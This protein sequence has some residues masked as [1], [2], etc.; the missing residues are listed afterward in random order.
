MQQH[1]RTYLL[2]IETAARLAVFLANRPKALARVCEALTDAAI[3]IYALARSEDRWHRLGGSWTDFD[4]RVVRCYS[5]EFLDLFVGN[6]D[7]TGSPIIPAMK[8]ANPTASVLNSVNHDVKTS[9]DSTCSCT[10]VVLI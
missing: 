8:G 1:E 6:C 9:R 3:N 7:T 4:C 2:S 5:R 10:L